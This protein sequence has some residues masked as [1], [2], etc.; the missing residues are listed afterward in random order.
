MDKAAKLNFVSASQPAL[1]QPLPVGYIP[2]PSSEVHS[3][4]EQEDDNCNAIVEADSKENDEETE[5]VCKK[6]KFVI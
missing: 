2:A 6:I 4:T 3:V 5:Q 1:E